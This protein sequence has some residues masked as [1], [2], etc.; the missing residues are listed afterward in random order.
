ML[1]ALQL[2]GLVNIIV[3]VLIKITIG[4]ALGWCNLLAFCYPG[5]G[6]P[7]QMRAAKPSGHLVTCGKSN[8]TRI[9]T[10]LCSPAVCHCDLL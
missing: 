9:S 6:T 5:F 8:S 7:C 1:C 4:D 10:E 2:P 3:C